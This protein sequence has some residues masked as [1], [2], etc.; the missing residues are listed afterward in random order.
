MMDILGKA[1]LISL[2]GL[3]L[4][5]TFTV[6]FSTEAITRMTSPSETTL[7]RSSDRDLYL[8]ATR[9]SD[10]GYCDRIVSEELKQRCR[11]TVTGSKNPCFRLGKR[12]A[13]RQCLSIFYY[14]TATKNLKHR[15]CRKIKDLKLRDS[16]Y[17]KIG[18]EAKSG[19]ICGKIRDATKKEYCNS[20]ILQ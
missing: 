4:V 2:A 3:A 16:C 13:I 6:L 8:N 1:I 14:E 12:E 9:M 17:M 10:I 11:A 7:A 18:V 20:R 5:L 19:R 15:T